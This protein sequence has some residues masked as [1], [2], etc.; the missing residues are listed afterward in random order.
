MLNSK[1][2]FKTM[3]IF[4]QHRSN[5]NENSCVSIKLSLINTHT[6]KK[7]KKDNNENLI[8]Q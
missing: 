6:K 3:W 1:F 5:I 7:E 8:L 4:Q 2:I